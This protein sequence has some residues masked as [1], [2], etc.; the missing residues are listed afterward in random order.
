MYHICVP[1]LVGLVC[2]ARALFSVV[3]DG[4]PG[5][6]EGPG[7]EG[8]QARAR[9]KREEALHVEDV[10]HRRSSCPDSAVSLTTGPEF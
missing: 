9:R 6:G 3:Q 2:P 5:F 4:W 7:K 10:R 1:Q 8:P